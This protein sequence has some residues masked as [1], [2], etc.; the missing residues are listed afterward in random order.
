M[1]NLKYVGITHSSNRI[2]VL[3]INI[4]NEKEKEEVVPKTGISFIEKDIY[5]LEEDKR[6]IKLT[7]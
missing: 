7:K 2:P 1:K 3:E 6:K 4:N 5:I